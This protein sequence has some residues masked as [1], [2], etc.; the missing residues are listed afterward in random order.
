M[1]K[2][3]V[4]G[5]SANLQR[6]FNKFQNWL[7][8]AVKMIGLLLNVADKLNWLSVILIVLSHA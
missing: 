3:M 2:D 1:N 7:K 4:D 8:R 6:I 5:E